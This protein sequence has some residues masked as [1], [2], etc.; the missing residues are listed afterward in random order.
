MKKLQDIINESIIKN[1]WERVAQINSALKDAE[2]SWC[3]GHFA[4]AF[5][6]AA[7]AVE[8]YEELIE[9]CASTTEQPLREHLRDA[10]GS[11]NLDTFD[12]GNAM[13][14]AIKKTAVKAVDPGFGE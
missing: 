8:A 4:S 7:E 13:K 10:V 14:S 12:F 3:G 6:C 1:I 9:L 5:R 2:G 11:V